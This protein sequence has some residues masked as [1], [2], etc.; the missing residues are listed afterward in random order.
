MSCNATL[1]LNR[2]SLPESGNEFVV[3]NNASSCVLHL[4]CFFSDLLQTTK[5]TSLLL[6]ESHG[7][8]PLGRVY[9]FVAYLK[10]P[11]RTPL[12]ISSGRGDFLI[13]RF[14]YKKT[15]IC[16]FPIVTFVSRWERKKKKTNNNLFIVG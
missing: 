8:Y 10:W 14:D 1:R 3:S 15:K 2:G 16:S 4:F 13:T 11:P 6:C 12:W 9:L 5:R 7:V